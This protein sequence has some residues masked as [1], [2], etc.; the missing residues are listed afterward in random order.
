M[1]WNEPVPG[2]REAQER[3][4]EIVRAA[5]A[6]RDRHARPRTLHV[7]PAVAFAAALAIVAAVVSP[8]GRAVLGST[9]LGTS[10]R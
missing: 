7:W 6:A 5:W 9:S 10:P 1:R 4:W 8:P 3:S 2:E